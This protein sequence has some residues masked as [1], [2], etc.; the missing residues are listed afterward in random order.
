MPLVLVTW[1]FDDYERHRA[2]LFLPLFCFQLCNFKGWPQKTKHRHPPT[3]GNLTV[4]PPTSDG[5]LQFCQSRT[6]KTRHGI[7]STSVVEGETSAIRYFNRTL[8]SSNSWEPP[9][10]FQQKCRIPHRD[11][12]GQL[13]NVEQ[14]PWCC[15][16]LLYVAPTD[17][18]FSDD[19]D[20]DDPHWTHDNP[21]RNDCCC[22]TCWCMNIDLLMLP[23]HSETSETGLLNFVDVCFLR[24]ARVR[25][26]TTAG[27]LVIVVGRL[28]GQSSM[29]YPKIVPKLG[30]LQ[31]PQNGNFDGNDGNYIYIYIHM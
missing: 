26:A 23:M 5:D 19:D 18:V 31:I 9:R 13:N 24:M 15:Y 17:D 12:T 21:P 2:L 22:Q 28:R 25:S 27:P 4:S 11:A 6:F 29:G 1:S 3:I 30:I 8:P 14:Q 16:M 10:A 20:D 7:L